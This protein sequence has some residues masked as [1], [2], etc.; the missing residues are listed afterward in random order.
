MF[1]S[2]ALIQSSEVN[3]RK[4]P[5]G[6]PPA[7]LIRISGEAVTSSAND[8][9]STDVISAAT[10]FTSTLEAFLIFCAA[11]SSASCPRATKT[12]L[13]PSSAS[14][15]AHAKPK[16][17]LPAQTKAHF[18]FK[19][20]SITPPL[21]GFKNRSQTSFWSIRFF[22]QTAIIRVTA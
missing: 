5:A 4:S 19:P 6:G 1:A 22:C 9:P 12:I 20:K 17:L 13:T 8:L 3:V 2:R 7:L 14:A 15:S 21:A 10:V 18:P 16:P 11:T